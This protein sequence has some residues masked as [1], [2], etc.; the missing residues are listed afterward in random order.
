MLWILGKYYW[1]QS[2]TVVHKDQDEADVVD[3]GALL[4]PAGVGVFQKE[5]ACLFDF[6]RF[7]VWG[8][9]VYNIVVFQELPYTIGCHNNN[10]IILRHRMLYINRQLPIIS[11]SQQTP[12]LAATKS[13]KLLV[14]ASPGPLASLNHTLNGPTSLPSASLNASTLPF[15]LNILSLSACTLGLWSFDTAMALQFLP[16]FRPTTALESPT[17]QQ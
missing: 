1:F 11:G 10:P 6:V 4:V 13:P 15:P 5:I 16:Y 7:V 2:G 14:M 3:Y 17:L 8:Q 9:F 12:T